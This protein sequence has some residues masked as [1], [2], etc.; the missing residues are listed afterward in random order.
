MRKMPINMKAGRLE[1]IEGVLRNLLDGE[2]YRDGHGHIWEWG[3]DLDASLWRWTKIDPRITPIFQG[4]ERYF[5]GPGH[6]LWAWN[7]TEV[8]RRITPQGP[9]HRVELM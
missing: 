3:L 9:Y 6:H 4:G 8:C 7:G 1:E 5:S 2:W